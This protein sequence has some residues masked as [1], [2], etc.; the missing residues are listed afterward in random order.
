VRLRFS[1]PG[2]IADDLIRALVDAEPEGRPLLVVSSDRAV[3]ED[4]C[5]KGAWAVASAVF[6]ELLG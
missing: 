2:Q 4:V 1:A 6:A 3:A 5:R